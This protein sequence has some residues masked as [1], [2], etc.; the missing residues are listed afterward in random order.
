MTTQIWDKTDPAQLS[1]NVEFHRTFNN[2]SDAPKNVSG[3]NVM[4]LVQKFLQ[5]P[6]PSAEEGGNLIP[7]GPSPIEG[8]GLDELASGN[9]D[10]N[11]AARGIVDVSVGNI[12]FKRMMMRKAE[13]TFSRYT[14]DSGY[15]ISCRVAFDFISIWAATQQMISEW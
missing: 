5:V 9:N 11:V 13:P 4:K 7:P 3:E 2:D 15:P 10:A 1:L 8:I 12:K 6:L 14:D